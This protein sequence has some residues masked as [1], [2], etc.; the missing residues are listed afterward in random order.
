[1]PP[2]AVKSQS[3]KLICLLDPWSNRMVLPILCC[4]AIASW[5]AL[6]GDR[7]LFARRHASH[8]LLLLMAPSL[9]SMQDRGNCKCAGEAIRLAAVLCETYAYK[10]WL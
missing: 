4:A 5:S 10:D 9:V 2:Q 3:A 1:M 7:V 8:A 6:K